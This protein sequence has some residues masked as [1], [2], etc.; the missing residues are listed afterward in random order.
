VIIDAEL[1]GGA[2]RRSVNLLHEFNNVLND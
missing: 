2:V 1:K